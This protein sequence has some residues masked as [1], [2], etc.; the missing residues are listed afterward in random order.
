MS[1]RVRLMRSEDK[2]ECERVHIILFPVRYSKS[3][4][5]EYLKPDHLSLLLTTIEDGSEKIIGVSMSFR[6]W[7]SKFSYERR[8]YLGTFGILPDYQKRG[9]GTYFLR[10]TCKILG[11]YFNCARFELHCLRKDHSISNF[12]NRVGFA[13]E[14]VLLQYYSFSDPH[15]DALLMACDPRKVE[16]DEK[17]IDNIEIDPEV[18][19]ML[20]EKQSIG[21]FAPWFSNP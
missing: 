6:F 5:D 20:N 11:G 19:K 16:Y 15:E 21:F 2:E 3:I 18:Q 12:Y 7:V 9:L 13:A 4:Y 17:A 10:L 1:F 8:C 14:D